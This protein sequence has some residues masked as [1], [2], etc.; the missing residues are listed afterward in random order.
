MNKENKWL[1]IFVIIILIIVGVNLL[2]FAFGVLGFLI[3]L[4]LP[5]IIIYGIWSY[6]SHSTNKPNSY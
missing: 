3:K 6:F 5:F 1:N 2:Q 4:A